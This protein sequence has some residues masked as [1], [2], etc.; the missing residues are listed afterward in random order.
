MGRLLFIGGVGA[1][2]VALR[3]VLTRLRGGSES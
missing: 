2:A 1:A 3:K